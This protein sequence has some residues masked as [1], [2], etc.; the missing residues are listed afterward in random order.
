ML[1]I[2]LFRSVLELT[3]HE[4]IFR[5][6]SKQPEVTTDSF[7]GGGSHLGKTKQTN[8]QTNKNRRRKKKK[9]M[10]KSIFF[11]SVVVDCLQRI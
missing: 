2:Q 8:K 3:S 4:P 10:K 5:S 7:R 9:I 11:I 6:N 1:C